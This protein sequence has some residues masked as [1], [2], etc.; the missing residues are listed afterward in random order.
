MVAGK[1]MG[2]T[3]SFPVLHKMDMTIGVRQYIKAAVKRFLW[4]HGLDIQWKLSGH[5][6][7]PDFPADFGR[8]EIEIIRGVSP[9]SLTSKEN[10][11]ALI[12]AVRHV[13]RFN[14]PGAIVECGVWRGGSMMAAAKTLTMLNCYDRDLY[15]FD[16]FEGM[17][18]PTEKDVN[19]L[20]E[21]GQD[22]IEMNKTAGP[23][24]SDLLAVPLEEV[25]KNLYQ[26]GYDNGRIRFVK[27]RV[28][29]T[30]PDQAPDQIAVLRLD[31]DWYESTR[32]ELIHLFPGLS[33]GGILI[34]DDYGMWLGQ[35]RAVDEY[36]QEHN[37]GQF[38]ARVSRGMRIGV[39]E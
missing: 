11:F 15:L 33:R 19:V 27:G 22:V 30:L 31:T 13:V 37:L 3:K 14:I 6:D 38:L 35:R 1:R 10:L 32:H 7:F 21:T 25:K 16:T 2:L 24:G 29:D 17:V 23:D 9:F 8:E 36:L 28:Q 5:P 26:V 20:G 34:L 4:A 12:E 18:A 39:K